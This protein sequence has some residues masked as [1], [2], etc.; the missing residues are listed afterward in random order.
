MELCCRWCTAS[1]ALTSYSVANATLAFTA[2]EPHRPAEMYVRTALG[3]QQ[4]TAL[5]ADWCATV[6]LPEPEHFI[7]HSDGGEIDAWVMRPAG[8][9]PGPALPDVGEHGG[10]FVQY[11]WTFFDEFQV[12]PAP[13]MRSSAAIPG[14]AAAGRTPAGHH[15]LPWRARL[16]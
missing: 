1:A 13:A 6:E 15:W 10:P 8:F 4:V 7:V 14:A 16:G 3:E 9:E 11:G 12:Q 2:A 5:N